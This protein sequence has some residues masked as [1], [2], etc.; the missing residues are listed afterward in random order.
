MFE[1]DNIAHENCH[2]TERNFGEIEIDFGLN[3]E[4]TDF[5]M[6]SV[7]MRIIGENG[8]IGCTT[9]LMNDSNDSFEVQIDETTLA[10]TN[11]LY[12]IEGTG[13]K[14]YSKAH[15]ADYSVWDIKI[16]TIVFNIYGGLI[17]YFPV[18]CVAIFAGFV[19]CC[20]C[21]RHKSDDKTKTD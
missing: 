10:G 21:C 20:L 9:S 16:Q 13:Y 15:V 11:P 7:N 2:F 19:A 18:V 17:I 5:E 3:K 4:R 1:T 6:S 14:C 12:E 8:E